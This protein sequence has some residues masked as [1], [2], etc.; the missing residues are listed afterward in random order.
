MREQIIL[1]CSVCKE[2]NYIKNKNKKKQKDKIALSKYCFKCQKH[3]IHKEKK[4]K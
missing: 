4:L 2:Q 3:N 1:N